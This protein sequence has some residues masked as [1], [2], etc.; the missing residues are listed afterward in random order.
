M[1]K[2]GI[3]VGKFNSVENDDSKNR[4]NLYLRFGVKS[5]PSIKFFPGGRKVEDIIVDHSGTRDS[6][7]LASFAREEA[8]KSTLTKFE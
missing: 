3:K 7:N 8:A 5:F 2:D 4:I 6:K 1:K